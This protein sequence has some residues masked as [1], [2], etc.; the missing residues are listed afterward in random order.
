MYIVQYMLLLASMLMPFS[1]LLLAPL[2]FQVFLLQCIVTGVHA[3]AFA[4]ATATPMLKQVYLMLLALL[5]LMSFII[6]LQHDFLTVCCFSLNHAG[7]VF[8]SLE[9]DL[10]HS[11]MVEK[12]SAPLRG[13]FLQYPM[14]EK[15]SYCNE[16]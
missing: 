13:T 6:V 3:L 16:T 12:S 8:Q 9:G 1:M 2:L 7:K 5:L 14:T 11:L 15:F 4:S 10:F